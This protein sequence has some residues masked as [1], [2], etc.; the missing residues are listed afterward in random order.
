MT[1][2]RTIVLADLHLTR[3]TP[4]R[5]AGTLV[6]FLDAHRGCRLLIAGDF[7]DFCAEFPTSPSPQRIFSAHEDL[8]FAFRAHFDAEGELFVVVG[9]HD[10]A[11]TSPSFATEL[12]EVLGVPPCHPERLQI[13]PWF[14]QTEG[15]FL[16]HGHRYDPDN[17]PA[18]PLSPRPTLLGTLMAEQV[19]A[20]TQAT[21]LLRFHEYGPLMLLWQTW[22]LYRGRTPRIALA[23]FASAAK[24]IRLSGSRLWF[25][26]ERRAGEQRYADFERKASLPADKLQTL[27]LLSARPTLTSSRA[28]FYRLRCD[29]VF[30]FLMT[31]ATCIL[32]SVT[33][34]NSWFVPWSLPALVFGLL[35]ALRP[36]RNPTSMMLKEA[37]LAVREATKAELV[38]FGHAHE[39]FVCCGY[40]NPGSF[41]FPHQRGMHPYL[42]VVRNERELQPR[43]AYWQSQSHES[44]G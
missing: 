14:L 18:H 25:E 24:A 20:R 21:A 33:T 16:E 41:S 3:D 34:A 2:R 6:R 7:F 38:I 4:R 11:M 17:A 28:T 5:I 40:A 37:A 32:A 22:I 39:E 12:R 30:L 27:L 26:E 19:L 44:I 15:I 9:N 31:A 29:R 36:A 8:M 35:F 23:F 43:L 1:R 42:E 10:W 13:H